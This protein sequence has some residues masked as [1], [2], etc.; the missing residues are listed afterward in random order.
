V[1]K[2]VAP[3]KGHWL[4]VRAFD[5]ALKRDA[6]GALVVVSAGGRNR[7]AAAN[8]GQSYCSSGDPRAHFGLGPTDTIDQIRID[9][10][11]GTR[12]TFPGGPTD[13]A[14]TLNKGSGR[15]P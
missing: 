10:P 11:D 5:P 13:R 9:W 7:V 6:Y 14:V 1:F 15:T 12:E 2:N 8:P 4:I 3:K